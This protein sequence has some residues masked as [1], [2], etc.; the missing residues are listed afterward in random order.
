MALTLQDVE[1]IQF[2]SECTVS[3]AGNKAF[4]ARGLVRCERALVRCEPGFIAEESPSFEMKGL[5]CR[6]EAH[7]YGM[8]E[9][10]RGRN[11]LFSRTKV[12]SLRTRPRSFEMNL[13][14]FEM[15]PGSLRMNRFHRER[16]RF[17]SERTRFGSG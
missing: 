8:N 5:S 7:L 2:G 15:N 14:S 3:I 9:L 6:I 1:E 10:S 16:S 12:P 4:R 17:G 11:R 13:A